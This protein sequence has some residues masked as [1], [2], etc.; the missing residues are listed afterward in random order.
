MNKNDWWA[1]IMTNGYGFS[2][3]IYCLKNLF[4]QYKVWIVFPFNMG[5]LYLYVNDFLMFYG[6]THPDVSDPLMTSF[7][8]FL[9]ISIV[10]DICIL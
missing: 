5:S 9:Y 10:F 2:S 6:N 1:E 8:F 7:V 3:H 4:Y